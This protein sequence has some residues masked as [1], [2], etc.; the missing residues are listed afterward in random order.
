MRV[1]GV[2]RR[3]S[4][5]CRWPVPCPSS[6]RVPTNKLSWKMCTPEMNGIADVDDERVRVGHERRV[7]RAVRAVEGAVRVVPPT[8]Y[9]AHGLVRCRHRRRRRPSMMLVGAKV[10]SPELHAAS[11][12]RQA[13]CDAQDSHAVIGNSY[14]LNW[15]A[16]EPRRVG[17]GGVEP[18][19]CSPMG[20][21]SRRAMFKENEFGVAVLLR[22]C[23]LTRGAMPARTARLARSVA[24]GDSRSCARSGLGRRSRT[25]RGADASGARARRQSGR[26]P[27]CSSA[28]RRAAARRG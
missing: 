14:L 3:A 10:M 24:R 23:R 9:D 7:I 16:S 13:Q 11:A 4:G 15:C 6:R 2:D 19:A 5:R 18:P 17:R 26:R 21:H 27:R 28:T 1:A 20:R 25:A 22:Q 8:V 12:A